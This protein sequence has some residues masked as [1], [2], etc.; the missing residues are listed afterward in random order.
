[1]SST[2]NERVTSLRRAFDATFAM[3]A[4]RRD[5]D[6]G[7]LAMRVGRDACAM[8]LHDVRAL[9]ADKRIAPLP[10][11]VP[12]LLGLTGIRGDIV[13]VYSLAALLG[14]D[15]GRAGVPRWLVLVGDQ[16]PIGLAFEEFEG[17]L[18]V[19]KGEVHRATPNRA[20]RWVSEVVREGGATRAVVEVTRLVEAIRP[21]RG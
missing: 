11:P 17:Y 15:G 3:P 4:R 10:T 19:A 6:A 8:R 9:V 1:M 13:P 14:D 20:A 21:A 18:S 16:E 12:E 2:T 5:P 7:F